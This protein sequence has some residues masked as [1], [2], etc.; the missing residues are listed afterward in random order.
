MEGAFGVVAA[1]IRQRIR[2]EEE[3]KARRFA[4]RGK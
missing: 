2:S 3:G 1:L 4:N